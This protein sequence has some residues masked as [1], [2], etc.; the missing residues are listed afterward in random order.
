[1]YMTEVRKKYLR[2]NI[3]IKLKH[4]LF[5]VDDEKIIKYKDKDGNAAEMK[6]GSAKT[7]PMDHPAKQA[8]DDMQDGGEKSKSDDSQK[9]SFDRTADSDDG[10]DTTDDM[11][12]DMNNNEDSAIEYEEDIEDALMDSFGGDED[13]EVDFDI[14]D[15]NGNPRYQVTIDGKGKEMTV[16]QKTGEV[17]DYD[18]NYKQGWDPKGTAYGNVNESKNSNGSTKLKDILES[19][20]NEAKPGWTIKSQKIIQ[21]AMGIIAGQGEAELNDYPG[22]DI[23]NG[24]PYLQFNDKK[25]AKIAFK[26]LQKNR[27]KAKLDGDAINLDE[28]KVKESISRSKP[29]LGKKVK[30]I[31]D[32]K[33][34]V[35]Y[36]IYNPTDFGGK[37]W[38]TGVHI[39]KIGS[40]MGAYTF[41]HTKENKMAIMMDKKQVQDY[42]KNGKVF[43]AEG[44]LNEAGDYKDVSDK[45]KN[46]LDDLPDRKFTK[47]NIETLIK[48]L[49]EKRP[50]AAMAY[51]KEAFG[52]IGGGKWLKEA[53]KLKN[54]VK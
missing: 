40:G 29:K 6:A 16:D 35:D 54:L 45:F 19:K 3:M 7:M 14:F 50:D 34:G 5:E 13:V 21:K 11:A 53:I 39:D 4:V 26:L 24:K 38:I 52:W 8:W 25:Q 23:D 32:I 46:A 15:K 37:I 31:R 17:Y 2:G 9:V 42:I 12:A 1:M 44:K 49:K 51:A 20:L 27:I 48:K 33:P 43:L 28:G 47:N 22:G 30:N 18:E 36:T 10:E 41:Y